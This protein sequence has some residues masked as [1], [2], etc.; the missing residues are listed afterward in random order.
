MYLVTVN[1]HSQTNLYHASKVLAGLYSL[2]AQGEAVVEEVRHGF[3]PPHAAVLEL[4]VSETE[5]PSRRIAIDLLDRSDLI[6]SEALAACHVYF[7]RNHYA[8]DLRR[9][10]AH[11]GK[12][13]PWG[14][15]FPCRQNTQLRHWDFLNRVARAAARGPRSVHQAVLEA[16]QF[17]CLPAATDFE[18]SHSVPLAPIV[19]YQTRLWEPH[20]AEPDD[21]EA[22]N[23]L[24]VE[25][26]RSLRRALGPA[27]FGGL[28]A[29]PLA[30]RQYQEDVVSPRQSRMAIYAAQSR[31]AL[32][33]VYTRGLHHSTAFKLAEY[34]AGSK[35]IV[36]EGLRNDTPVKLERNVHWVPFRDADECVQQ[37]RLL[38]ADPQRCTAMREAAAEHYRRYVEPA[39]HLRWT[40]D[41]T[42][43]SLPV[44]A[45]AE[46]RPQELEVG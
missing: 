1:I 8:P 38:L 32:I 13:R 12:I 2:A 41:Q 44:R 18:A 23:R 6:D 45:S 15:N 43:H 31:R 7:K 24:R 17:A 25:V 29:T 35:V 22:I 37:C 26:V 30:R 9:L 42:L 39:A 11:V 21:A 14:L 34:L 4:E 28:I 10:V 16:R 33:G 5:R 36:A 19:V 27:F 46:P 40:L 3:A 20:E